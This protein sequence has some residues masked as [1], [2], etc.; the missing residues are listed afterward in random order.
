MF[1]NLTVKE[2]DEFK[3]H[4]GRKATPIPD[5]IM[6]LATRSLDTEKALSVRLTHN[7]ADE[8][9]K[10]LMLATKRNRWGLDKRITA[11]TKTLSDVTF[12]VR[13][14]M[15]KRRGDIDSSSD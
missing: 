4:S 5:A 7:E 14:D 2:V 8:F 13:K 9:V 12:K 6:E 3:R 1:E 15:Q 10:Y 11:V